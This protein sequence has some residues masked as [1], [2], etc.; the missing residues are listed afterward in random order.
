MSTAFLKK[1]EN[2]VSVTNRDGTITKVDSTLSKVGG[3]G[4]AGA[5]RLHPALLASDLG[6]STQAGRVWPA[7][8]EATSQAAA[9]DAQLGP[10]SPQ[11]KVKAKPTAAELEVSAACASHSH[12]SSHVG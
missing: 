1:F 6:E 4:A 7:L 2:R 3:D 12:A 11:R 5:S 8:T 10:I 9:D